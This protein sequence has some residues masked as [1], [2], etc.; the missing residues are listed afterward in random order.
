[1]TRSLARWALAAFV[2]TLGTATHAQAVVVDR[3]IATVDGSPVTLFELERFIRL[4]GGVDPSRASEADRAKALDLLIGETLVRLESRRLGLS[5]SQQDVDAYIE[6]IKR[7][8]D[9]DDSTLAEALGQQ[10]FT[11]E[12]YKYQIAKELLKNQLVMRQ[13]RDQVHVTPADVRKYYDTNK[14]Q[15]AK[16]GSVHIR[17]IFF[18]L[19]PDASEQQEQQV[20][21]LAQKALGELQAGK[22]F[23]EVAAR[24]SQGPEAS[25][26]GALG[27]MEKGQMIPQ[28]EQVVFSLRKG[29][30]GPPVRTGAGVHILTVDDTK[31]SAYVPFEEVKAKISERLYAQEVE[32]RFQDYVQTDLTAGHAIVRRLSPTSV[33]ATTPTQAGDSSDSHGDAEQAAGSGDHA[34]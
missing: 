32:A 11:V 5:V 26:G 27:W 29:Q 2:A 31:A 1:M 19:P 17:Q 20:A 22:P 21:R 25:D 4:N 6:E 24:Y 23:S 28:L 12:T 33:S 8:N 34:G 14:D 3:I 16:T 10:G 18:V 15:F 9:L 13:I 7:S 30:I